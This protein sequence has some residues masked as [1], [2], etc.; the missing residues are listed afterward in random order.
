MGTTKEIMDMGNLGKKLDA[1]G[2][3]VLN[4]DGH[5][6]KDLLEKF[7][8][9]L[10]LNDGKP[11]AIVAKTVKGHGISFMA[12]NN[13]WHYTRLTEDTYKAA[14]KELEGQSREE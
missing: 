8:Q 4:A 3:T 6:E 1:F 14:L 12:N 2:F 5:N 7:K 11:K 10:S 9:L 13:V